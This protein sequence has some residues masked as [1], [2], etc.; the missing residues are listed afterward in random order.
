MPV[1][2][3]AVGSS[4]EG[5]SNPT[6]G[7]IN[8]SAGTAVVAFGNLNG[9][10]PLGMVYGGSSLYMKRLAR[11]IS[12]GASLTAYGILGVAS[13]SANASMSKTGSGW[14]QVYPIAYSGLAGFGIPQIVTGN[15]NSPSQAIVV[16]NGALGLQAFTT[17]PN[18]PTLS[19]LT[20]GTNRY[21]DNAGFARG[22]IGESASNVTFGC[23]LSG[24]APW[25][26]IYIPL[27]DSL[28]TGPYFTDVNGLTSNLNGGSSSFNLNTAIG[29][30]VLLDFGQTGTGAPSSVT[31]GGASMTLLQNLGY[32]TSNS[33]RFDRYVIG[34]LGS[35]GSKSIAVTTTAGQ[36][37]TM[38]AVSIANSGGLGLTSTTS[39]QSTAP[40]HAVTLLPGQI[41]IQGFATTSACNT[42]SGGPILYDNPAASLVFNYMSASDQSTTFAHSNSSNWGSI[43]TVINPPAGKSN[44]FFSMF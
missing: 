35:G 26:G 22:T 33:Y 44:R 15:S 9:D 34:P 40:S 38:H 14:G 5:S 37:W 17:G 3:S 10:G 36:W 23:T 1:A 31:C 41:A 32:S 30:Y 20:G 24:S 39:G 42:N 27:L 19:A 13:G 18:S 29:D 8:P 11:V 25:G 21:L 16:P 7:S 43:L 12:G 6:T 28:P 2:Y 4:T